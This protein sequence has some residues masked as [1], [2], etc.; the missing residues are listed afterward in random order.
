M[1][2]KM[3]GLNVL[4]N[5]GRAIPRFPL[6]CFPQKTNEEDIFQ[7][8][9]HGI[10]AF[11]TKPLKIPNL[12]NAITKSLP[13]ANDKRPNTAMAGRSEVWGI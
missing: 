13:R 3:D 6:F 1:I 2:P 4:K 9:S 11:A 12:I 8:K 10:T 5:Y 7:I